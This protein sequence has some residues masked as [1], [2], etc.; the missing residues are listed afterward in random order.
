MRSILRL[1]LSMRI[2]TEFL[3]IPGVLGATWVK[4]KKMAINSCLLDG[5]EGRL[6]FTC[7]HEI[8][9]WIFHPNYFFEQFSRLGRRADDDS[10]AIICRTSLSKQRGEWQADHF[11]GALIM[12]GVEVEDAY[13]KR[14]RAGAIDSV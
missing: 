6:A 13:T 7:G 1:P 3:G 10:P 4:E 2:L 14:F 8:G 11:S 5:G 9:H 12:P